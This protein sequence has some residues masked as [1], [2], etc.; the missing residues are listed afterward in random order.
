MGGQAVI[1]R[2]TPTL[3]HSG[4]AQRKS[5]IHAANGCEA[6]SAQNNSVGVFCARQPAAS[7][8]G[9]DSGSAMPSGMT[10]S[11]GSAGAKHPTQRRQRPRYRRAGDDVGG[12]A[13]IMRQTPTLRHSGQ[14]QR[15][16][17]IHAV[18]GGEAMSVQN[19]SGCFFFARQLAASANGMDSRSAMPSGMTNSWG[20]AIVV[21]FISRGLQ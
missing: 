10:T 7:A 4:Q 5:G 13:I 8:K 11:W 21:L 18:D 6:M 20:N 1:M 17:G 15:R 19:N 12:Q 2:Q 14:A 3:R 16:S 9:M